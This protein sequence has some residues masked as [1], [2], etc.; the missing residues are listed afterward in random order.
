MMFIFLRLAL[1]AD[2]IKDEKLSKPPKI[3]VA[4]I[5][6]QFVGGGMERVTELLTRELSLNEDF[7]L[8]IITTT[9]QIPN[10][11]SSR[12]RVLTIPANTTDA[13]T[14]L[15]KMK[16]NYNIDVFV[17]QD[18]WRAINVQFIDVLKSIGAKVIAFEHNSFYMYL[19]FT[20]DDLKYSTMQIYSK[21]DAV[22]TLSRTDAKIWSLLGAKG[23]I[24]MPNLLTFEPADFAAQSLEHKNIIFN[25]RFDLVQKRPHVAI[26]AFA[27]VFQSHPDARLQILGNQN[28]DYQAYCKRVAA[29]LNVTEAVDFMGYQ[30]EIQPILKNASAMI[31]T[32]QFEGFPM[33][34][35][36]AKAFGIPIVM[37][38]LD[39]CEVT[40][41]GV[42][43]VEKNDIEAMAEQLT[44]LLDDVDYRRKKGR[45]AKESLAK[46]S[47]ADI[48][49]RWD[50]LIK[51]VMQGDDQIKELI[52]SLYEEISDEKVAQISEDEKKHATLWMKFLSTFYT[53]K[54]EYPQ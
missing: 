28:E 34:I 7:E 30:K 31:M 46:F 2:E 17:C 53:E 4:F 16:K 44:L 6:L 45:E 43:N 52:Q 49:S 8:F 24:Y 22:I 29:R 36:E 23:A 47:N 38:K 33:V 26:E 19:Y 9:R 20:K 3:K 39:Y 41:E 18:H 14:T 51:A 37:M 40:Q 54:G 10:D 5:L 21:T 35:P 42:I 25:G 13:I 12:V 50:K 27:K 32:S 11:I 15:I 48:V 1:A